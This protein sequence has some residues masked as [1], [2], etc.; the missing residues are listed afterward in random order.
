M[1]SFIA[2]YFLHSMAFPMNRAMRNALK[3]IFECIQNQKNSP[4]SNFV[5][6]LVAK[7][8]QKMTYA[9]FEAG[10]FL[11]LA[12]FWL[13]EGAKNVAK[14]KSK[15]PLNYENALI[16]NFRKFHTEKFR[17]KKAMCFAS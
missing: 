8:F 2:C 3:P 9:R 7:V 14:S 16:F 17:K 15:T 11:H 13:N 10:S 12:H 6:F 5:M 1:V 4:T